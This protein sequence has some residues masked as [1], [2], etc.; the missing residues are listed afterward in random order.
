LREL[1]RPAAERSD[2][3]VGAESA[4]AVLDATRVPDNA[5]VRAIAP[6]P[7]SESAKCLGLH[8]HPVLERVLGTKAILEVDEPNTIG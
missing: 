4:D 2:D 7:N 6:V 3:D 1:A 8:E 5:L